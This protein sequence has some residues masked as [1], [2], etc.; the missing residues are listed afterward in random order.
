LAGS[1]PRSRCSW[2]S[3]AESS[4]SPPARARRGTDCGG[5]RQRHVSTAAQRR[6][7]HRALHGRRKVLRP[8][9]R[10]AIRDRGPPRLRRPARSLAARRRPAATAALQPR[11][12]EHQQRRVGC[13]QQ[14]AGAHASVCRTDHF[15]RGK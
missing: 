13:T 9:K 1:A 8:S 14:A 2:R 12:W 7:T 11:A 5:P 10:A 6:S 3:S 4:S 15:A